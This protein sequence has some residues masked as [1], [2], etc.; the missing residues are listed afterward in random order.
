M[1]EK[2]ELEGLRDQLLKRDDDVKNLESKLAQHN[3]ELFKKG[4]KIS[5]MASANQILQ[6]QLEEVRAETEKE[7]SVLENEVM[8]LKA[9]LAEKSKQVEQLEAEKA[10]DAANDETDPG[11]LASSN[12]DNPYDI[13][14]DSL[15]QS[16]AIVQANGPGSPRHSVMRTRM[17]TVDMR[18]RRVSINKPPSLAS[19]KHELSA[20]PSASSKETQTVEAQT[21]AGPLSL[22][23]DPALLQQVEELR[24]RVGDLEARL[25]AAGLQAEKQLRASESQIE[26]LTTKL[27][28]ISMESSQIINEINSQYQEAL[29][30][31]KRAKGR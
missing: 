8:E 2:K 12:L 25:S 14:F 18:S 7:R 16:S 22:A 1:N 28:N 11:T 5:Q 17:S 29:K 23:Q 3:L 31:L 19:E 24:A 15:M 6:T 4:A 10:D 9:L 20:K 27:M 26:S 13:D 30:Q 21:A